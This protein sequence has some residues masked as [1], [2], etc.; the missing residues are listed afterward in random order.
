MLHN[1]ERFATQ[2]CL[3]DNLLCRSFAFLCFALPS[4]C[5]PMQNPCLAIRAIRRRCNALLCRAFAI[6]HKSLRRHAPPLP[7]LATPFNA[8]AMFGFAYIAL[9]PLRCTALCLC[10]A[11]PCPSSAMGSD[12]E[13]NYAVA[14]P[15][16]SWLCHCSA[17]HFLALA[18]FT[19]AIQRLTSP[20]PRRTVPCRCVSLPRASLLYLSFTKHSH[21]FSKQCNASPYHRL[22]WHISALAVHRQAIPRHC[23]TSRGAAVPSLRA[24]GT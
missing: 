4:L 7:C 23:L 11:V 6:L 8:V 12:V 15:N 20:L 14:K 1:A 24:P 18:R 10:V 17:V 5:R 19:I 9:A 13:R 2:P 3:C 21:R 16:S 22:A